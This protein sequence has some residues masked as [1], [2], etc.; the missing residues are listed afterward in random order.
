LESQEWRH[1]VGHVTI[2]QTAM[3]THLSQDLWCLGDT[4]RLILGPRD[5]VETWSTYTR[6]RFFY[7]KYV[8]LKKLEVW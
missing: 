4:W 5:S 8:S 6:T 3:A 2:A 1:E 7:W